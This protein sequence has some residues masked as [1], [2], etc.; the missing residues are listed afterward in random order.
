MCR[1][2]QKWCQKKCSE[3][4]RLTGVRNFVCPG[5]RRKG[6]QNNGDEEEWQA[7]DYVLEVVDCF[8]YLGDMLD[9][10]AGTERAVRMRVSMAWSKWSEISG[11]LLN[12]GIPLKRRGHLYQA[13]VRAALMYGAESWPSDGKTPGGASRM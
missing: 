9:C 10:E 1:L 13:C 11:L 6:D 5:C 12:R 2:C 4:C 3:F 7:A 8:C